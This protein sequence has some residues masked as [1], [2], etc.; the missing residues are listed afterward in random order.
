MEAYLKVYIRDENRTPRG[1]AVLVRDSDGAK[2]LAYSL[3][4]PKDSFDKKVGVGIALARASEIGK[5]EVLLPL[6]PDRRE[7]VIVAYQILEKRA[8]KYYKQDME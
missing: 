6:V 1:V 7:E 3:C 2:T 8:R 4:S 5:D